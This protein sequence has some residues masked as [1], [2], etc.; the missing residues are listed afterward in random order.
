MDGIIKKSIN[1]IADTVEFEDPV[2]QML[3]SRHY[4]K[5]KDIFK[6]VDKVREHFQFTDELGVH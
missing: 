2:S 3:Q 5:E 4:S 6:Y 1:Q